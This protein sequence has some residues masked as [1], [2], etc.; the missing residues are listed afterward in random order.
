MWYCLCGTVY[1]VLFTVYFI[2]F[3]DESLVIIIQTLLTI[4]VIRGIGV[5]DYRGF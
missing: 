2:Q 5:K 3:E 1:V 4:D